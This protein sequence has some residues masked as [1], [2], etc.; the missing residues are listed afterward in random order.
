MRRNLVKLDSRVSD[1]SDIA[2]LTASISLAGGKAPTEVRLFKAGYNDTTKG[3]FL[4]D[5][6]AAESVMACAARWGNRYPFDYD[7][8]SLNKDAPPE[9]GRAAGHYDLEVRAGELWAINIQWTPAMMKFLADGEFSYL[10]PAFSVD[11]YGRVVEVVN[12]AVT[13]LPATKNAAPLVQC[14]SLPFHNWPIVDAPW[15]QAGAVQRLFTWATSG[16]NDLTK[17]DWSKYALG[18]AWR[19]H[20]VSNHRVEAYKLPHHDVIDG[21][22]VTVKAGV[23][24]AV[25][26]LNAKNFDIPTTDLSGV[27]AH[28]TAH[29]KQLGL[30]VPWARKLSTMTPEEMKALIALSFA[31]A[32]KPINDKIEALTAKLADDKDSGD[33]GDDDDDD[34]KMSKLSAKMADGSAS[35]DEQKQC[36][37]LAKKMGKDMPAFIKKKIEKETSRDVSAVLVALGLGTD[38][39]EA[40]GTMQALRQS[41]EAVSQLTATVKALTDRQGN[42][43][44]ASLIASGSRAGKLPPAMLTWAK[45]QSI[46]SLTAFLAAAPVVAASHSEHEAAPEVVVT[47]TNTDKLML[48]TILAGVKDATKLYAER[49]QV[50]ATRAYGME[51]KSVG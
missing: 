19:D 27:R 36:K 47:N 37:S 33:D 51:L 42:D 34:K 26:A 29:Y 17:M 1:V 11:E 30:T 9:S 35:A 49:K 7:H 18:F 48:N 46:K 21:R 40:A 20:R 31:E 41:G 32:V 4:F 14:K 23:E 50:N 16:T 39:E 15:D 38:L 6:L 13:N 24:E 25:Q 43:E 2:M 45:T 44:L 28:L 3:I 5:D 22:I 10:S 12:C 8:K